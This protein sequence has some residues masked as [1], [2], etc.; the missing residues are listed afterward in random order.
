LSKKKHQRVLE[1]QT[2][3]ILQQHFKL[4]D[5]TYI[6][7]ITKWGLL[8]LRGLWNRIPDLHAKYKINLMTESKKN[9][10]I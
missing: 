7:K 1:D 3:N 2:N 9:I 6:K 10:S 8:V 5:R 4:T